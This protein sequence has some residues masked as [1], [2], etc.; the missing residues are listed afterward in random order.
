[1]KIGRLPIMIGSSSCHLHGLK[2]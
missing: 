2:E 1:V